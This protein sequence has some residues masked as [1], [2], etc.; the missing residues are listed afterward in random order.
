MGLKVLGIHLLLSCPSCPQLVLKN[1]M[2]FILT[3]YSIRQLQSTFQN[4]YFHINMLATRSH[5]L[6]LNLVSSTINALII[7]D[8]PFCCFTIIME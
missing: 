3:L 6:T 7:L 2:A 4:N 1:L 5:P 8:I